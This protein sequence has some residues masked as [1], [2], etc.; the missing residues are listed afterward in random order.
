M[1][2]LEESLI[3]LIT[4]TSTNLPPVFVAPTDQ[5]FLHPIHEPSIALEFQPALELP[6]IVAAAFLLRQGIGRLI[7]REGVQGCKMWFLDGLIMLNGPRGATFS[8]MAKVI[9]FYPKKSSIVW[10]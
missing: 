7:R 5:L 8:N 2:F 1:Q 6:P 4:H 3:E 10:D 9:Q